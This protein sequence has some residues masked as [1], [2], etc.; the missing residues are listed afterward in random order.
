MTSETSPERP[1]A[2][3]IWS[4]FCRPSEASAPDAKL[5]KDHLMTLQ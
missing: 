1:Q 5:L 3:E 4:A 2:W